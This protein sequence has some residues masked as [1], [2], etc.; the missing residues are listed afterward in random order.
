[1]YG[2]GGFWFTQPVSPTNASYGDGGFWFT[3]PVSPDNAA[4]GAWKVYDYHLRTNSAFH[5]ARL[6][7]GR[8]RQDAYGGTLKFQRIPKGGGVTQPGRSN[9]PYAALCRKKG[10]WYIEALDPCG[11]RPELVTEQE[12]NDYRNTGKIPQVYAYAVP[13]GPRSC[14]EAATLYKVAQE[15]KKLAQSNPLLKSMKVATDEELKAMWCAMV[16]HQCMPDPADACGLAVAAAGSD[17]SEVE[18]KEEAGLTVGEEESFF[19]KHKVALAVSGV[20][21]VG[22]L[23]VARMKGWI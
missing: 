2:D 17:E 16:S 14:M 10:I 19:A 18:N 3:Q 20:A 7:V 6:P 15:T 23:I 4:Y 9:T 13:A 22:S 12:W 8:R 1:M 11:P 21:L 5:K